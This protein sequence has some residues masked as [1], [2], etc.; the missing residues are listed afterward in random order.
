MVSTSS[1]LTEAEWD[2]IAASHESRRLV[3]DMAKLLVASNY[4][5]GW[6]FVSFNMEGY[7]TTYLYMCALHVREGGTL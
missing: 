1:S 5:D 2:V 4:R 6:K 3:H 7:W